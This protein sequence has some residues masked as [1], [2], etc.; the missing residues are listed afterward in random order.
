M[1]QATDTQR[2]ENRPPQKK[3]AEVPG[4]L[5]STKVRE[6]RMSGLDHLPRLVNNLRQRVCVELEAWLALPEH[7]GKIG[8]HVRKLLHTV[9]SSPLH[10]TSMLAEAHVAR[11]LIT[12][13]CDVEVEVPTPN[14]RTCDFAVKIDGERFFL[15]VKCPR[16]VRTT[17]KSLPGFLRPIERCPRP[18]LVEVNWNDALSTSE[19]TRF[20]EAVR[21]FVDT[22]SIGE[23][24]LFRDDAGEAA[25]WARIAGALGQSSTVVSLSRADP[26]ELRRFRRALE[27]AYVQFMPGGE[28]VILV[29]TEEPQHERLLDV[30]LRGSH[31]ERWDR[32]PGPGRTV[33]HGRAEDGF[34]SGRHYEDSHIVGWMAL[35]EKPAHGR[36][37][38]R[39]PQAPKT[40]LHT[41]LQALLA[42]E[43]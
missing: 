22:A 38:F 16:L 8:D 33:A 18:F 21:A 5:T 2:C 6:V 35:E 1:A 19:Q 12:E 29:L 17:K 27:R 11:R 28:N 40:T 37:W 30:A 41:R 15:H 31:V 4:P 7:G 34:W 43:D 10:A 42:I 23:E 25:G 39:D 9:E 26:N 14:G 36:L 3:Q 24:L 13:G 32:L 20:A